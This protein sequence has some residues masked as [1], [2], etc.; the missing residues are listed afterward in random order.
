LKTLP[1]SFTQRWQIGAPDKSK[2]SM[3]SKWKPREG[4]ERGSRTYQ[5]IMRKMQVLPIS[6]VTKEVFFSAT[7]K[8]AGKRKASQDISSTRKMEYD[9][10]ADGDTTIV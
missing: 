10:E 1:V 4:E 3:P 8:S 2:P 5:I 9:L 7:T 6:D